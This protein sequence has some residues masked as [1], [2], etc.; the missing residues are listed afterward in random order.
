M[1]GLYVASHLMV[2]L[3]CSIAFAILVHFGLDNR[4]DP[5]TR[6]I[7]WVGIVL[8]FILGCNL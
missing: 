6:A 5:L 4:V 8:V 7:S 2:L 3:C 1:M